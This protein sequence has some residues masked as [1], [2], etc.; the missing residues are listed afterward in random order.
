MKEDKK[1]WRILLTRK[2]FHHAKWD[3]DI[4][5]NLSQPGERGIFV[6]ETC[7]DMRS[8]VGETENLIPECMRR[9]ERPALPELSQMRVLKH[10]FKIVTGKSWSR[11]EY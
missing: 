1:P 5:Y 6:P 9:K 4:I 8:V 3:E 7:D 11:F 2:N 10:F